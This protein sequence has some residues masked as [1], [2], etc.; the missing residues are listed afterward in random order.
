[1]CHFKVKPSGAGANE[2]PAGVSF[3]QLCVDIAIVFQ[4]GWFLVEHIIVV[5]SIAPANSAFVPFDGALSRTFS[6]V[7]AYESISELIFA[8]ISRISHSKSIGKKSNHCQFCRTWSLFYMHVAFELTRC[9][10]LICTSRG[11][12]GY[13]QDVK[14]LS[15]TKWFISSC[16]FFNIRKEK[17]RVAVS[18]SL[19]FELVNELQQ[20]FWASSCAHHLSRP[21]DIWSPGAGLSWIQPMWFSTMSMSPLPFVITTTNWQLVRMLLI[22]SNVRDD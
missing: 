17:V 9:P 7:W 20:I 8:A 13:M 6:I 1:M 11:T 5:K 2:S 14:K 10:K 19:T 18:C 22:I 21:V 3:I 16:L 12:A 4:T 15:K